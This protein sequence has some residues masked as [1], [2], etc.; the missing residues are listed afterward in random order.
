MH[1]ALVEMRSAARVAHQNY[2]AAVEANATM[3]RRARG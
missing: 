3:F 1:Q 2:T